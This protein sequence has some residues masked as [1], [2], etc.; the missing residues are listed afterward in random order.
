MESMIH[1]ATV[2]VIGGGQAAPALGPLRSLHAH[3]S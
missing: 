1:Q 3:R 2:I